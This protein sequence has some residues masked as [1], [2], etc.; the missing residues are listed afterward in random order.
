MRKGKYILHIKASDGSQGQEDICSLPIRVV[1]YFYHSWLFFLLLGA[2]AAGLVVLWQNMRMKNLVRQREALQATVEARTREIN[3]QKKL[4]EEKAEAL[5]SQNRILTRQN[6]ELA[7]HKILFQQEN[8]P[9]ETRD[10]VF[11]AKALDTIRELYKDPDLDVNAFCSAMGMSK[12]LLNKRLQD[13]LGQSIG[14]FIRKYRLSIAREIIV[15]NRE[16]HSMNISEIAYE[17]GFNDPRY[18]TRCFSK[19]FGTSPSTYPE[20]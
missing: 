3:R 9:Y 5:A 14:Q 11:I 17:V 13:T 6:E 10:E 4:L 7:G 2:L 20:E 16:T 12:T 1:P 18:F 19:E 8:H 15:N